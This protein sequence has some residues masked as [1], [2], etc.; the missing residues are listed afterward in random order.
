FLTGVSALA[1]ALAGLGLRAR[2][3]FCTSRVLARYQSF[4]LTFFSRTMAGMSLM[5][6]SS[7]AVGPARKAGSMRVVVY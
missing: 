2:L 4:R 6:S 7:P 1:V 3:G 5:C